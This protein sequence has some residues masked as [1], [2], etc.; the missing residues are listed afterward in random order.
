MAQLTVNLVTPS[1]DI[2][3]LQVD[4]VTAPSAK[5]EVGI[6]PDHLPLL[7]QLD[8]GVVGLF[9][10]GQPT[11]Y[12]VSGGFLEVNQNTVD[13][14]ADTAE[15]AQEIDVKRSEKALA[16]AE[17]NLKSL[18]CLSDEY[19]EEQARAGRARIRLQV[20]ATKGN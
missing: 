15:S 1:R 17:S 8:P 4:Q 9:K 7:A 16:E 18:D 6:L 12:A 13:I 3:H 10:D 11:F 20:A 19:A 14:L 5:G 2:A